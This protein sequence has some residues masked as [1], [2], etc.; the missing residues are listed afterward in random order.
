MAALRMPE[1]S[2]NAMEGNLRPHLK[3]L[4]KITQQ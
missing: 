4:L 2:G 1:E 3:F